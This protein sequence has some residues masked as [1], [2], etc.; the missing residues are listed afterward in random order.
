MW[1]GDIVKDDHDSLHL[2]PGQLLMKDLILWLVNRVRVQSVSREFSFFFFGGGGGGEADES[3]TNNHRK[4][5]AF[6][7]SFRKRTRDAL[8]YS[9][10]S[11]IQVITERKRNVCMRINSTGQIT[12]FLIFIS[13]KTP[14]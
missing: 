13:A 12:F 1:T 4:I 2:A 6:R 14:S 11:F 5:F 8:K 10:L 3:R 7:V 9:I